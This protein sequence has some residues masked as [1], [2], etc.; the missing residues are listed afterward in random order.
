MSYREIAARLRIDKK[1]VEKGL[2][3]DEK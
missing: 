1:T 3:F 2:R